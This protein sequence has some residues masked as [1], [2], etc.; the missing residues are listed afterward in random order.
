MK[1]S[2]ILTFRSSAFPPEEGEDEATNPG[3]FGRR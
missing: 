2:P 3:I 1:Q